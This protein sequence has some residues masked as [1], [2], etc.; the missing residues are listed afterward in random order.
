MTAMW[1]VLTQLQAA[2]ERFEEYDRQNPVDSL[3]W[4]FLIGLLLGAAVLVVFWALQY[5]NTKTL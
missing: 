1:R 3:S 2:I 4:A 5:C